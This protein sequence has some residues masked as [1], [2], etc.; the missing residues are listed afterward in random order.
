M[1]LTLTDQSQRCRNVCERKINFVLDCRCLACSRLPSAP[2][3]C[4]EPDKAKLAESKTLIATL[5]IESRSRPLEP[6]GTCQC[7]E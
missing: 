7:R 1:L 4:A 6:E 5:S 3:L 2:G